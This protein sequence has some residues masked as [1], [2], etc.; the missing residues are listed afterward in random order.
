MAS[1]IQIFV[2]ALT[3]LFVG[4]R[5]FIAKPAPSAP[6]APAC[7]QAYGEPPCDDNAE[8]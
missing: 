4:Y 5:S 1:T 3:V 2:I 7:V 8:R 6:A